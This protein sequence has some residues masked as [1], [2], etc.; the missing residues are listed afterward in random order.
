MGR[1]TERGYDLVRPIKSEWWVRVRAKNGREGWFIPGQNIYGRQP[2]Y[3][4]M[5]KACPPVRDE[6]KQLKG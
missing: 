5:P 2:H 6:S 1:Y 4:E 3:E